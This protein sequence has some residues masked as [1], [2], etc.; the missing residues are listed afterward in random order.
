MMACLMVLST[1]ALCAPH[2]LG[3]KVSILATVDIAQD[4]INLNTT[5]K[6]IN[7][8][9]ELPVEYNVSDIVVSTI[10]LN[11]TIPAELHPTSIGDYDND[12]FPDLMVTFNRTKIVEWLLPKV[13][14]YGNVTLN[15]TGQLKIAS[16]SGSDIIKVSRLFGD[17]DCNGK[18]G[19]TDAVTM[20]VSYGRKEGDPTWNPNADVAPPYGI[21][22]IYDFVT[23]LSHYGEKYP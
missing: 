10:L 6:W 4:C 20:L 11:D 19:L 16:F 3:E 13:A 21:I 9:I 7:G 5:G 22:N 15:L 8:Y 2:A 17:A 23:F 1:F 12:A 18:V 14:T